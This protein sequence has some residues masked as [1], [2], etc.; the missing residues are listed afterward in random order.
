MSRWGKELTVALHKATARQL[1][2]ALGADGAGRA[3]ELRAAG[4]A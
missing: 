4:A 3:A 2:S 1:R